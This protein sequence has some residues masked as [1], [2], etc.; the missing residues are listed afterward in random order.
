M[1]DVAHQLL[2]QVGDRGEDTPGDHIALDFR[3]P[4]FDL[5]QPGRVRRRVMKA[6]P[7]MC[8]QER[9]DLLRLVDRKIVDDDVDLAPPGLRVDD[10]RQ[11]GDELIT[12]VTRYGAP[13]HFACSDGFV[14]Q[15][16]AI[17]RFAKASGLNLLEEFRD[18][19]VSGAKELAVRPG[20]AA[21]LDRLESNG[22]RT[23]I[24]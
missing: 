20:L 1:P 4:K 2:S 13:K 3:K 11:K 6:D 8:R 17:Q 21:L 18:E 23:V 10:R 7:R 14:R 16:E 24:V 19:G 12:R 15:R 5:V 9:A 22:V